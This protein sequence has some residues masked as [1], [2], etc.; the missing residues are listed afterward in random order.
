MERWC[1]RRWAVRGWWGCRPTHQLREVYRALRLVVNCFQ[2]SL[3]LQA[4]VPKGDRVR[5]VYDVAQTPLAT[6][7]GL[8]ESCS[9]D[10]QR[11]LRERVQQID[12]LALSEHLDALR[13]ALWCVAHLP[14]AVAADGPAGP[15][16]HFSLAACTSVPRLPPE[17]ESE[18]TDHH[19]G[20]SSSEEIRTGRTRQTI[21]PP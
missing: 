9:E 18:R 19:E 17:E 15:H 4:K 3:K 11:D 14:T 21:L 12:P 16:L 6:T 7:A 20:P 13:H 2:P 10:R 5:R 8:S 1:A